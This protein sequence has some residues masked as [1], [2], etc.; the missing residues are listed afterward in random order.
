M[1]ELNLDHAKIRVDGKWLSSEELSQKIKDK[2]QSGDMKF[3]DL[4]NA[5]EK[6][7]RTMENTRT[8]ELKIT[9][10]SE[11]Y[12]ILKAVGGENDSECIR[13][14]IKA[15]IDVAEIPEHL[16]KAAIPPKEPAATAS[17]PEKSGAAPAAEDDGHMHFQNGYTG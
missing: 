1:S 17:M 7:T 5:L 8:M 10:S 12:K 14:A 3:A 13:K 15:Y 2:M 4:A 11:Q 16:H 6:L 9:L